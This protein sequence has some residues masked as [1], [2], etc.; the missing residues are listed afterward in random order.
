MGGPV[1]RFKGLLAVAAAVA[2][3]GAAVGNASA[4][5]AKVT[6]E[7]KESERLIDLTIETSAYSEPT[8]VH[9][10]LPTGYDG[11]PNKRWPVTYSLAGMQNNYNSFAKILKGE[12][13]TRD[14]PS[15]VVSPDG[16]SGFWSDWYN[17]GAGGP[18]MYESFVIGELIDLIDQ[19]YRTIPERS[20]RAIMGISMGGYGAT[21][22]AARHPDLFGAVATLSGAVDSNNPLIGTVMSLAPT[23]DGGAMDSIYG[24]RL[25]EEVRWRG[26]NPTD[27][28]SNLRGMDIQVRT[29][30]GVLN[31][32]IG[33]GDQP[34]DAASCLVENGV[35]QGS[36]SF[37]EELVELGVDHLWKDYGNGCHTP[38]N[39]TREV[40]DTMNALAGN[41]ANPAPDPTR[42][43]FK[44]I[45]PEFEIWGWKVE[46]D[47]ARALEFMT[48]ETGENTV[49]LTGSGLTRVTSPP[50]YR[51]LKKVDVGSKVVRPTADGTVSFQVDLGP[52]H[53]VQQYRPGA[54]TGFARG[55]VSFKP[56]AVVRI[57]KAKRLQRGVR[58][59]AKAIGGVMPKARIKSGPRSIR[60]K[61]TG[62]KTCRNL[63]TGKGKPKKVN[64][65]GQDTYG[66]PASAA[67]KVS[68]RG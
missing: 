66:H 2:L 63:K 59:C 36:T 7:K 4:D 14:Y 60:V 29:A 11:N 64:I 47:P 61:L 19:R 32:E 57:L 5:E 3:F 10:Y 45:E 1:R 33:E 44:S 37:H 54:V 58:V 22:L 53:T 30:N 18:P 68:R 67:R 6:G 43:E 34:A 15:I 23:F 65:Q 50:L 21:S 56:H 38:E 25:S 17:N 49:A 8:N 24:P 35:Y 13:M 16:N 27:L 9:V 40:V 52:A 41:F 12:E 28:A 20:Q 51:G 62:T 31:P 42:F 26:S 48:I 39:F 46:A 55:Q